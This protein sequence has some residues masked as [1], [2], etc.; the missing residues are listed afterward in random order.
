MED[1]GRYVHTHG[2]Q[3]RETK[4]WR[5]EKRGGSRSDREESEVR[6]GRNEESSEKNDCGN[7]TGYILYY[8]PLPFLSSFSPLHTPTS[9]F[10]LVLHD[11]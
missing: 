3:E 2:R 11:R 6:G 1:K 5:E 8:Y 4:G 7:V 9:F 10:S